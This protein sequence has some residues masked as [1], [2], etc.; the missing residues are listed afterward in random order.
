MSSPR[1]IDTDAL[2]GLRRRGQFLISSLLWASAAGLV[3]L[4][5]AYVLVIYHYLLVMA[6]RLRAGFGLHA[7]THG[8][9]WLL[10]GILSTLP[11]LLS[12]AWLAA[13]NWYR[14]TWT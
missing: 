1:A 11:A 12:L 8:P 14:R 3:L 5:S 4:V 2:Q 9:D 10:L 7:P 6:E 13:W